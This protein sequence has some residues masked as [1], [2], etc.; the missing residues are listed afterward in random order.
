ML[1]VV[2]LDVPIAPGIG[3]QPNEPGHNVRVVAVEFLVE[4]AF[5]STRVPKW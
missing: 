3:K 2:D 4:K 5:S 1:S